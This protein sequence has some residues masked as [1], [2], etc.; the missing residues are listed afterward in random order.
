M[1]VDAFI[2]FEPPSE[3]P[4]AESP[5]GEKQPAGAAGDAER[6]SQ[7]PASSDA[8]PGGSNPGA[9]DSA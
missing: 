7:P 9:R 4:S 1:G 2:D 8:G 5:E 3:S 6:D